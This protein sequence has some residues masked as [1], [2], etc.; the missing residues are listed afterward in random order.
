MTRVIVLAVFALAV[1]VG[2]YEFHEASKAQA[3][4]VQ[5]AFMVPAS[6]PQFST[7]PG[8]RPVEPAAQPQTTQ[9]EALQLPPPA[10]PFIPD[11]AETV[12]MAGLSFRMKNCKTTVPNY[13]PSSPEVRCS[14]EVTA[15]VPS[16]IVYF[17]DVSA[18]DHENRHY[19][20]RGSIGPEVFSPLPVGSVVTGTMYLQLYYDGLH[21]GPVPQS[22]REF[23][24]IT[25]PFSSNA[26]GPREFNDLRAAG[27]YR[28]IVFN[29][30]PIRPVAP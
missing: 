18:T 10:A 22:V 20:G 12:E 3:V 17:S 5:R 4:T 8:T 16:I 21:S 14:L 30:V 25:I 26:F 6:V 13:N 9:T 2:G 23:D 7:S 1:G 15:R 24:Q 28:D 29:H 19:A 27:A 11:N